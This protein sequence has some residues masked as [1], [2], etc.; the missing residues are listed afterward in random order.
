MSYLKNYNESIENP[1]KFW[2]KQAKNLKWYKN[3]TSIL[4]K[5]ENGFDRWFKDGKLN[6]CY[7]AVDKHIEDGFGEQTAIIYDSPVTQ[8]K[9]KYSYN[10][11]KFQVERLAG[12]LRDLGVK[13]GDTVI[14][15][16]PMIPHAAFSMLACARIGAI[17]SVVF[18]G[19][20][21]HELAIRIDD[22][23]PKVIITATSGMEVDRLIEYKPLVIA[24]IKK[25]THKPNKVIVYKRN[26]GAVNP[27]TERY[28]SYKKLVKKSKPV[29]CIEMN[30]TDPLYILYTS[31][32]TG[33]PKGILRDTGGYAVALKYSMKAIYGVDPGDTY[34]AASDIGWVVGHSYIVY[35]PLL[36]RNTTIIFEGK[37]IKTPDASTFWRIISEYQVKVMFTAPTAIRAIKKED[38]DGELLK[39][40]DLTC[41]KYQF[42]AGERCDVA[43]LHWLEE[44]LGIPVIDH[45][46]QTESGWPMISNM[47]GVEALPIKP[48]SSTKPVSGYDIQILN[49]EGQKL[50]PNEEGYVTVKLPLPP[51]NLLDIWGNTQ[52]FIDGYL[53][54]FEGYY[55]SGDGG[56][57]DE[58]GYVFITGRVDDVINV[59]G[60][61]LSTAEME[62]IVSSNPSVAECAV[63][64]IADDLKGQ[65]PLALV[66]LKS[67]DYVSSFELE[68]NIV[69]E[70]RKIIG[71][72]ASL[73]RVLIVNRL[74]KTRSGKI[75]RKLLRNI[76]DGVEYKIPST[77]DDP[78]IVVEIEHELKLHKIGI[79]EHATVEEK[80]TLED[81]RINS[82]IKYYKSYQHSVN[83]PEGYW[84]QIANTFN[85]HKKWDKVLEFNWDEPKFEWFKGAKLNITENCIDRHLEK[86]GDELAI[87]W[88][89]N[90]PKEAN[91]TLTYK[92][93]SVEVNKFANVLKSK[94]VGKGDR[95]C[96]YMQMVPEL[97]I[98][99]LA[100]ARIGA[101][102]S[103]VFAGFSAVALSTR[104]NDSQCKVL[105]T[106]D[107]VYRGGKEV[108]LKAIADEALETCP[109][110]ETSIVLKR[111]NSEVT[112]KAG[113]D[114][115]W[116]DEIANAN[117]NCTAEIMDAED[118][119][120]IL[121]TSGSTGK[122]KGMVHTCGGYMVQTAHSFKN[123]FQYEHGD[124]YF[125]T[126]DIGWITGHS[127]IVY[128][129][130]AVGAT[131]LMFEGVPSY[132]DYSR[133]WAI[134]E[135]YKVTQFYTAP[136]AIRALAAKGNE[137][138]EIHDLSSIKILGTVG[139]PINE[140]AWHW[141]DE[142]I[143]KQKAPIVDTWWQTETGS[144][145][146][147]PLGGVTPTKPTFA[148][149]PMPG[150]QPCLVDEEGN[151]HNTNPSEGRLCIKYPWPSMARTI[152]GNHKRYKETYFSAFPGKYFTGDGAF[153]DLEGNYRITGRVDD[154]VI[155]SG[156]N[157]GTA[158]IENIINE[159][160]NVV[161]S[162]VVGYPHNIKGSALYAYVIVYETPENEDFLRHEINDLIRRTI[163]PIAK[164]DKIQFVPGLP[165]TR[166]GKIMRRILRKIAE[167]ETSNL[168]DISTLL[169]PDIVE[170]IKEGSLVK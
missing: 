81:L 31:G 89:P 5:D 130:L 74:P 120:F 128:G 35:G 155:V 45:W 9:R 125:C 57:K 168:G 158:P 41:L 33:K 138:T 119:L 23:K 15:Y 101:I 113:R 64:G 111:I 131:T 150:V 78:E 126:A 40:Y 25:A 137:Y 12:G 141:Y 134:V 136:T 58:D 109:T 156:H 112:M 77:I 157:L 53:K 88:E 117:P 61:R 110:I 91:R 24:A 21:P 142:K 147:S 11:V 10:D 52:R 116:H 39:D 102:H 165:K 93:L 14:I 84:A 72:I 54:Q 4:S 92:Q 62:E 160:S 145:M 79:F 22:C 169:N 56:Y 124:V 154:V 18:G 8:Q 133:F 66:V 115:W 28:V 104:I 69:H 67:G 27:K 121:Y 75:L 42:L 6:I 85:W 86:R 47:M 163:G 123:V 59:A 100:C 19:F 2:R 105:L 99:V 97:A 162:A 132:P 48:G 20:A 32:T 143:G 17:H 34:W 30:S 140:E 46:W 166:S 26:L 96:M 16:M 167:N 170:A 49:K 159:H 73:K 83:D 71:P 161:E 51:G 87:I 37:P 90:D 1:E 164:L 65:V 153:R 129:P 94:G 122:P 152:Y 108:D 3:P 70:V 82:F 146:I 106:S 76:A 13:K 63:F 68:Y 118:V 148:T 38:P 139:E 114:V 107:G 29:A 151:E 60:H 44:N 43:T 135:K 144:I 80:Q 149:R 103:V 36:N 50:G 95:V 98:A 127:Y 55:F 7:L